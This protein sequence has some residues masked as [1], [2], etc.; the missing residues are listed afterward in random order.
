MSTPMPEKRSEAEVAAFFAKLHADQEEWQRR[1][2]VV[3]AQA[4]QAYAR[5]LKIAETS[6][7]GQASSVALFLAAT[8][9]GR[10]YPYDLYEMRCLDVAIGDDILLCMDALR[11][12]KEDLFN[13]V[14]DGKSRIQAMIKIW[15]IKVA[16]DGNDA[17]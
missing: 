9:N 13:L 17:S 8:Y 4:A 14:P 11:W 6:D 5:L 16:S 15:K 2:A 12:A 10:S 1:A 7:T 3:Q